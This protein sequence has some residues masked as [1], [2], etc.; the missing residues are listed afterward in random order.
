[1]NDIERI[2]AM[3]VRFDGMV[4]PAEIDGDRGVIV[5]FAMEKLPGK[6]RVF[7]CGLQAGKL[8]ILA[9]ILDPEPGDT[10]VT[11]TP[12]GHFMLD[13]QAVETHDDSGVVS[14]GVK[15]EALI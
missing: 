8:N 2:C 5:P 14:C 9:A 10:I 13:V 4:L 1:M 7:G 6:V 3:A 12:A 15:A 11:D